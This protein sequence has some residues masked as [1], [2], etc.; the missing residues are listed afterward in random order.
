MMIEPMNN[1]PIILSYM[2]VV[3]V[4]SYVMEKFECLVGYVVLHMH[5]KIVLYGT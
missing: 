2:L 5:C 3:V 4:L 1:K